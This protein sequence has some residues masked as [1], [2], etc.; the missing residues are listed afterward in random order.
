MT[1]VAAERRDGHGKLEHSGTCARSDSSNV[2]NFLLIERFPVHRALSAAAAAHSA[3]DSSST[4]STSGSI[5]RA[6]SSHGRKAPARALNHRR[7]LGRGVEAW[8][9]RH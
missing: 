9:L 3:Y 6:V 4:R 1:P 2:E 5:S 7:Q 8:P